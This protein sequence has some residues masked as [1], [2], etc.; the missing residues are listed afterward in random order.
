[1]HMQL[2]DGTRVLVRPIRSTD[3]RLLVEGLARLSPETVYRRF[4]T[5][6]PRLTTG[7]LRYLT[8][9]DGHDHVAYVCVL[10]EQPDELLGVG[11]WIRRPDDP[12]AAEVAV[13]V[14]DCW[15]GQGLG[16]RLGMELADAARA[17]GV[18]RFTATMAADNVP[19]HRL[20]AAISDRLRTEHHGGIDELEAELAA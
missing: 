18:G 6:K 3:K 17:H 13:V 14:G 5:P 12:A 4:L 10:A 11:R 19:A 15:Q 1:M 9:I 8:E 16:R 20:F 2:P 7:E